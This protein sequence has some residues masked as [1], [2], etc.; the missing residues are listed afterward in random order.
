MNEICAAARAFAVLLAIF[1]A[2]ITVP[3][4]APLLLLSGGIAAIRNDSEKNTRNFIITI[5]LLL[6]ASTL[7][8]VPVIGSHLATIFTS[9]GVAFVGA[10]MIAIVITLVL[11]VKRDWVK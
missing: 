6:G 11:R 5:V 7:E 8:V 3:L 2:F 10:S 9:L 4:T 1:S